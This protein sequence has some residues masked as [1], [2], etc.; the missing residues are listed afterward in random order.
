MKGIRGAITVCENSEQEILKQTE[1]LIKE[2]LHRNQLK[3]EEIVAIF[4]SATKDLTKVYPAKA[5]RN[6]GL[7]DTAMACYTEM[8]VEGSLPKCI[9]VLM[10]TE[11][12]GK[13]HHVYLEG[14]KCLRPDWEE[15]Y[16]NSH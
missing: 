7:T 1:C 9:R 14:A 12:N 8:D 13:P 2:I 6:M 5:V 4:F 11:R 15:D 10:I 3:E 16:A